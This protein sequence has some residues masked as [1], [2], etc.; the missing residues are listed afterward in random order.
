MKEL[1]LPAFC[2]EKVKAYHK[3]LVQL[4]TKHTLVSTEQITQSHWGN[5]FN[6]FKDYKLPSEFDNCTELSVVV[7]ELNKTTDY[8]SLK[9]LTFSELELKLDNYYFK[10]LL[11]LYPD[12]DDWYSEAL[13]YLA[14]IYALPRALQHSLG[15]LDLDDECT[16]Y[17]K[18]FCEFLVYLLYGNNDEEKSVFVKENANVVY[19][20][21][22]TLWELSLGFIKNVLE[23]EG[24][25]VSK[26]FSVKDCTACASVLV[27]AAHI[28]Y[29]QQG[30][31]AYRINLKL[32]YMFTLNLINKPFVL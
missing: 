25:K 2:K 8:S 4:L 19:A 14:F 26:D 20:E 18:S 16:M 32:N 10:E 23:E 30:E 15:L 9:G 29:K 27:D 1:T 11:I 3:R 17:K 28:D 6:S 13:Y 5:L 21:V 31:M 7:E 24:L 22:R 12:V